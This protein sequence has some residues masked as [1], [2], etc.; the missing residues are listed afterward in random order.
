MG[1]Q[2]PEQGDRLVSS[3]AMLDQLGAQIAGLLPDGGWQ[4]AA[5]QAY[6]ARTLAQS[7]HTALM[8]DLDRLTAELVSDQADTLETGRKVFQALIWWTVWW[9]LACLACE[10]Q[11]NPITSRNCAIANSVFTQSMAGL[12][13][14]L[15]SSRTSRNANELQAVTQRLTDMS[16]AP[17]TRPDPMFGSPER[18]LPLAVALS[19]FA[20][21]D[22]TG[23]VSH[24]PDLGSAFAELPGAPEFHLPTGAI[25]GFP[26]F[27]APQ[28]PIPTL[29]GMPSLPDPTNLPDLST[30]LAG[31]PT[32]AQLS[33]TLSQINSLAGPTSTVSQLV[34]TATQ[35]VQM[36]STLAQRGTPQH[37]PQLPSP[38]PSTAVTFHGGFSQSSGSTASSV[39]STSAK[40]PPR[41]GSPDPVA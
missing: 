25:G 5:A 29:T 24:I 18:T 34:N 8:A 33:A 12:T 15:V 4:G 2:S 38:R 37:A 26:D 27:G 28:L 39:L 14:A 16:T 19:E 35:H 36:I 30:M 6:G 40:P 22:H 17:P 20:L 11:G 9:L 1:H 7:R 32:I 10:G 21:T 31:L 23:P 3:G 41:A 13:L